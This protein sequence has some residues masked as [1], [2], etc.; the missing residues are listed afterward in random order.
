MN[1]L[2]EQ[3]ETL[4]L[5]RKLFNSACGFKTSV[6][7]FAK[8]MH[9]QAVRNSLQIKTPELDQSTV[10]LSQSYFYNYS[11]PSFDLQLALTEFE[12]SRAE[13]VMVPCVREMPPETEKSLIDSGFIKIPWFVESIY[14]VQKGPEEDLRQRLG[15]DRFRDLRRFFKSS[16]KKYDFSWKLGRAEISDQDL[17]VAARL[18]SLNAQ[19]YKHPVDLYTFDIL[20][21]ILNSHLGSHLLIGLRTEK[22]SGR[23]I[24]IAIAFADFSNKAIYFSVLGKDYQIQNPGENLFV[25]LA[26]DFYSY[27]QKNGYKKIFLGRGNQILKKRAGADEFHL[28]SNWLLTKNKKIHHQLMLIQS[29]MKGKVLLP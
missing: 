19:K 2:F 26:M 7:P 25:A 9:W 3:P 23:I 27:A 18:H 4:L 5:F 21:Q 11:R 6:F 22:V 1:Q 17:Q 14:N 20:Q 10:F 28:L 15:G 29:E 12:Q 16:Q 24:Q 8:L 13:T